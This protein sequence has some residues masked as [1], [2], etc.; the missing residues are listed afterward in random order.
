MRSARC[1][2]VRHASGGRAARERVGSVGN[3]GAVKSSPSMGDREPS[4]E[5]SVVARGATNF[6]LWRRPSMRTE[7]TPE[8]RGSEHPKGVIRSRWLSGVRAS[9]L[10]TSRCS[11]E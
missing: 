3:G 9:V 1:G 2:W 5:L 6:V 11:P 10:V 8:S 4:A 7:W